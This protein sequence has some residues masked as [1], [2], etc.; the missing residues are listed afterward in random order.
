MR[1]LRAFWKHFHASM[2][3][4]LH[5]VLILVTKAEIRRKEEKNQN[6]FSCSFSLRM[7]FRVFRK[8]APEY[9]RRQ[10]SAG[11]V[12]DVKEVPGLS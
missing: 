1:D 9:L 10:L 11:E 6:G 3:Y 7:L 4:V 8:K 2:K 5:W 12:T